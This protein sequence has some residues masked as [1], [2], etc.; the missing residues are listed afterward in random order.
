MAVII[1]YFCDIV[2]SSFYPK[3]YLASEIRPLVSSYDLFKESVDVEGATEG[4]PLLLFTMCI[5]AVGPLC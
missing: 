1:R 3:L 5:R 2:P 4:S